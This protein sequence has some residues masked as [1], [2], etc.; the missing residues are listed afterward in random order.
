MRNL[1]SH[2]RLQPPPDPAPPTNHEQEA[3]AAATPE[4]G[5]NAQAEVEA[6]PDEDQEDDQE[7]D[8]RPPHVPLSPYA[9]AEVATLGEGRWRISIRSDGERKPREPGSLPTTVIEGDGGPVVDAPAIPI[10]TEGVLEFLT[11]DLWTL[12]IEVTPTTIAY[13]GDTMLLTPG[14]RLLL[15]R[16]DDGWH[17]RV[18]LLSP[19]APAPVGKL[20]QRRRN[21]IAANRR[22]SKQRAS[23]PR[24][25]IPPTIPEH[26]SEQNNEAPLPRQTETTPTNLQQATS[27]GASTSSSSS[28]EP[29]QS[30]Y[31]G[32]L[33]KPS[34]QRPQTSQPTQASQ[35][36]P[37]EHYNILSD[38]RDLRR[39]QR[40]RQAAAQA[41][42]TAQTNNSATASSSAT[43]TNAT[44]HSAGTLHDGRQLRQPRQPPHTDSNHTGTTTTTT[45]T[46][47]TTIPYNEI[48]NT[49]TTTSNVTPADD[50]APSFMQTS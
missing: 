13:E 3:T 23:K 43:A 25:D 1:Q 15:E 11:A 49:T 6:D 16:Q 24:G 4:E 12:D 46:A 37:R 32:T 33:G 41:A 22:A 17:I 30:Y 21:M 14:D 47:T 26:S 36:P 9:E 50:E 31:P 29:P 5:T 35:P 10:G 8:H 40:E 20:R 45:T 2:N 28:H 27:P 19:D 7:G 34:G 39:S 18:E 48:Y 44:A 42:S 38:G